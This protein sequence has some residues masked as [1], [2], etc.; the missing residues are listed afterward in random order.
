VQE[1]DNT[2]ESLMEALTEA[3]QRIS[4]LEAGL[5]EA[6]RERQRLV[7]TQAAQ[8]AW[9]NEQLQQEKYGRLQAEGALQQARD[10]LGLH[11]MSWRS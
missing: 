5:A 6:A 3:Q 10:Q 8:L 4:D 2:K 1:E 7:E 11:L 9:L